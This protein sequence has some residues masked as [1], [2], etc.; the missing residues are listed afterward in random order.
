MSQQADCKVIIPEVAGLEA[1]KLTVGRHL[2]LNCKTADSVTT[3]DFSKADFK[4][5][6]KYTIKLFKAESVDAQNFKLN[7]TLY[8]TG[9][10]QVSS[11]ILTDGTNEINLAAPALQIESVLEPTKDGKPQEP[12]GP[13]LPLTISTPVS[14]YFILLGVLSATA[15]FVFLRYKKMAYYKKLKGSL[16]QFQSP[17][18]PET[19]FYKAI[20]AAEKKNYPLTEIEK[21][22]K[23]Y[24]LRSYQVPIFELSH[25]K[26]INYLKRMFPEYKQTRLQIQ[27]VL[28]EIEDLNKK[29]AMIRP[30]EKQE[31]VKKLYRFVD[32]NKGLD[33]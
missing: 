4:S 26:S 17:V 12:Y 5:E 7:L 33:L 18:D 2:E 6:E 30:D 31:F 24:V 8:K 32:N 9:P 28:I 23:L 19:Q 15:L 14:Y 29:E 27:K 13:L 3:F 20:R 21:A 22:F 16:N 11:Y 10:V 25:D 1:D